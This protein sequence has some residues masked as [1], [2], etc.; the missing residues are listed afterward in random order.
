ML[1]IIRIIATIIDWHELAAWAGVVWCVRDIMRTVG[2]MRAD[3]E[4]GQT[5]GGVVG[6]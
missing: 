5:A 6:M 2:A 3:R 1:S 4:T